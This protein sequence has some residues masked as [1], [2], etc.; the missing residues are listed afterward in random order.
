MRTLISLTHPHHPRLFISTDCPNIIRGFGDYINKEVDYRKDQDQ[1]EKPR[2]Y[3]DDEMDSVRY[4][5]AG[6]PRYV[7]TWYDEDE[8][9]W[10]ERYGYREEQGAESGSFRSRIMGS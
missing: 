4:L 10:H 6:R 3:R 8:Q 2:K 1:P 5:C 9:P 7:S